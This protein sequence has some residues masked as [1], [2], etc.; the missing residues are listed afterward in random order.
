MYLF[1]FL[2]VF[3][4]VFILCLYF[5]CS[6]NL[7]IHILVQIAFWFRLRS[8]LAGLGARRSCSFSQNVLGDVDESRMQSELLDRPRHVPWMEEG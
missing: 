5:L 7:H 6:F 2:L 8:G 1:G 4:Y 3:D